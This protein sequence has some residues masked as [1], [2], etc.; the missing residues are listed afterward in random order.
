M[1]IE[2]RGV[3]HT[4]PIVIGRSVLGAPIELFLP[5]EGGIDLL[6]IAGIHGEES[7]GTILLSRT[8]RSLT[9][10]LSRCGVILSLNPDGVSRGT[11]GNARGVDLNRN[12]PASNWTPGNVLHRWSH[13][14]EQLVRLSTGTYAGSEPETQALLGVIDRFQPREVIAI[15][16][17]L[18]C[19]DD[20]LL[21]PR[22]RWLA[23]RTGLPLVSEIGYPTPGSF[24]TWATAQKLSVITW[25]F[26]A[27]SVWHLTERYGPIIAEL[28]SNSLR[29]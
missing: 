19:V 24:G 17:P 25:E 10:P 9:K 6:L 8:L 14:G 29:P 21:S 3:L 27:E 4:T 26:P 23:Q 5:E 7:D 22:G 16:G 13:G 20:P 15:H 11:R 18:A 12:F 2:D 1:R 28:M